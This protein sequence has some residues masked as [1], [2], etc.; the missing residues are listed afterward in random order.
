LELIITIILLVIITSFA[1]PKFNTILY[2]SNLSIL[3]SELSLIQNG[4][5][6]QK[7]KNILLSNNENIEKLDEVSS[8]QKDEK[9]FRKVIDFLIISTNTNEKKSGKWAKISD[10]SYQFY[11]SSSKIILFSFENE[12]FLCKSDKQI[13]EEIQ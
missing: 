2:N 8:N 11:V 6:E 4:I 10:K 7:T 9:L 5:R 1:I 3:K 12:N 13:C